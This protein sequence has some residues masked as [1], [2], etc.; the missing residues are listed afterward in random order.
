[1]GTPED[2]SKLPPVGGITEWDREKFEYARLAADPAD[3]TKGDEPGLIRR[4]NE[5]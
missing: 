4:A 5:K 3:P 1:M 2:P